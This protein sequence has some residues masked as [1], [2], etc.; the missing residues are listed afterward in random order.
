MAASHDDDISDVTASYDYWQRVSISFNV[1][2]KEQGPAQM[3][4]NWNK[5]V[6][7]ITVRNCSTSA[8]AQYEK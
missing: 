5:A 2:L 6:K 8:V 1:A 3:K 7:Q 4:Q